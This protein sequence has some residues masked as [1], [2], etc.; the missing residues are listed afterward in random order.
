[1][2]MDNKDFCIIPEC[3]IDTN[4]IET[5]VPPL[6]GY[7]HQKGC[8][9]VVKT[10]KEKLNKEFALGIVDNDKKQA[11]YTKEFKKVCKTDSLALYKHP[12]KPHY[13]IMISPAV[14][15]FILKSSLKAGVRME[16]FKL[17][18]DLDSFI[19]QTK[20]IMSKKDTHFKQLFKQIKDAPEMKTLKEWVNYLKTKQYYSSP[21]ELIAL[22][23]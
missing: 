9:N 23:Q 8:N 5:L 17:S 1:M 13:L 2:T 12:D 16:D 19:R 11:A 15:A 14:D 10:M 21:D 6:K 22:T 20:Q 18:P 7:N 4:L 3:Y